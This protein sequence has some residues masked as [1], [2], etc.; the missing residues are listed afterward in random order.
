M[1]AT[2]IFTPVPVISNIFILGGKVTRVPED[3]KREKDKVRKEEASAA[4]RKRISLKDV[5]GTV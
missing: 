2:S 5:Q 1:A 4:G 3:E